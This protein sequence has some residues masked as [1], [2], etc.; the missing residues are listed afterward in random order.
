MLNTSIYIFKIKY[1][2]DVF[3]TSLMICN[4]TMT[5]LN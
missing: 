4:F 3:S 2:I 5:F 1:S